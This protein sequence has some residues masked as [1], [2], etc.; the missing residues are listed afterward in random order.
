MASYPEPHRT[1]ADELWEAICEGRRLDAYDLLQRVARGERFTPLD[2]MHR[3]N[4]HRVAAP[5]A[6]D[7][8]Q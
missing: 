6:M 3:I 5:H 7:R 8:A 4:P 2:A 1:H